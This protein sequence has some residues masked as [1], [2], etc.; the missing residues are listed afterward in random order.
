MAGRKE[1]SFEVRQSPGGIEWWHDGSMF[2]VYEERSGSLSALGPPGSPS[3]NVYIGKKRGDV[4]RLVS[5]VF[6]AMSCVVELTPA[7]EQLL[8]D[9]RPVLS[10]V[11][12]EEGLNDVSASAEKEHLDHVRMN[13]ARVLRIRKQ[14]ES[15][16]R[17]ESLLK[18][19]LKGL[20]DSG[21][22]LTEV[23]E[24]ARVMSEGE[25]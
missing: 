14:R 12:K 18:V 2:M 5:A 11:H 16:L 4:H 13:Y 17:N 23:I 3:V 8:M 20:M 24:A 21:V 6:S 22:S 19:A 10:M 1:I 15:A 9:M 7:E 25:V